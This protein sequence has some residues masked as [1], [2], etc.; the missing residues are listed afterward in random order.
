MQIQ[1]DSFSFTSKEGTK[2]IFR[3]PL[4]TDSALLVSFV[5]A[6]VDEPMSGLMINKKLDLKYE[7]KWLKSRLEEIRDRSAVTLVIDVEGQIVGSCSVD[8]R[9]YKESHRAV[10]GIALRKDFRGKGVGEALMR[11]TIRLAQQRMKGIEQIDLKTFSYNKRA[12]NLYVKLGF[13][14]TGFV[15]RAA[16][17]GSKYYGEHEMVLYL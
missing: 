8:R 7:R 13:V 9:R 1:M 3:E 5:N 10:L 4:K 15:P 14:K 12:M 6:V 17:E 16:K 11:R 2:V